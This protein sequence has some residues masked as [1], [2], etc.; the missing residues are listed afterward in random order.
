MST[1]P[2]Q[3]LRL[4]ERQYG[5][6]ALNRELDHLHQTLNLRL[7]AITQDDLSEAYKTNYAT[8]ELDTEAEIIAAINS[9]NTAINTTN[10]AINVILNKIRSDQ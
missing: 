5:V 2:T 6:E 9:I 8:G 1:T 3:K 7:V 10:A 4:L